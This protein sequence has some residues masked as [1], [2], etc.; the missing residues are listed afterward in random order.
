MTINIAVATYDAIILGCDSLSSVSEPVV[1]FRGEF[2]KDAE[3]NEI[4]DHMGQ[5]VISAGMIENVVATVFGGVNK[6]FLLYEDAETSVAAVTSGQATLCGVPI[7]EVAKRFRRVAQGERLT[8]VSEVATRFLE[9]VREDWMRDTDFANVPAEMRQYLPVLNFL[10]GGFGTDAVEG[11]VFDLQ[12]STGRSSDM[13]E[14]MPQRCGVCWSGQS[15]YV[16]RLVNGHDQGMAFSINRRFVE[17]LAA[18]RESVLQQVVAALREA[19]VE[20]PD[21]FELSV[22]EDSP[23]NLPWHL[24][25]TAIDYPN[26]PVQY[27]IEL[28]EMLVNTQSGMQ[29]FSR[30]VPTVGGRTHIGVLR[31]GEP[32]RKLNEPKLEHRHT[33]Y[34]NDI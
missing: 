33:G 19:G 17:D 11:R 22:R 9:F 28:A 27:A 26:L 23:A 16:E 20:I 6:M 7:A 31:R 2:A 5:R 10:V 3:G 15:N 4:L 34:A 29:H 1:R 8:S 24:G 30:G 18:Q 12:V 32:F 14:Q 21:G 25:F 13:F